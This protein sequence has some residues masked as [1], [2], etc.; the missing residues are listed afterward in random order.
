EHCPV[1]EQVFGQLYR[2]SSH[3]LDELVGIIPVG[4]RAMLALYCYR[5][6][7]LQS[8]GLAIAA[9]CEKYDLEVFG[10][11]AGKVLF[12]NAR[13]APYKAPSSHYLERRKVTLSTGVLREFGQSEDDLTA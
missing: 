2:A 3:E 12:E 6:A 8:I 4:T 5:R 7:H 11:N 10:G 1:S 13:K 9:R